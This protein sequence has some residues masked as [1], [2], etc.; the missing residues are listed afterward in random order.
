MKKYAVIWESEDEVIVEVICNT[1]ADAEE[2]IFDCVREAVY[3]EYCCGELIWVQRFQGRLGGEL[4]SINEFISRGY[5][6]AQALVWYGSNYGIDEV[7][8][9]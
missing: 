8:E 4:I 3:L 5:P 6:F 1:R 9:Y 7:E 2:Y